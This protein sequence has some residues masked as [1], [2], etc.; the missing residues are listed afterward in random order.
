MDF[1]EISKLN[2]HRLNLK[3]TQPTSVEFRSHLLLYLNTRY[4]G[5]FLIACGEQGFRVL[6]SVELNNEI[7][8]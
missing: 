1:D 3:K 6:K 7:F 5:F 8:N 2:R 4:S